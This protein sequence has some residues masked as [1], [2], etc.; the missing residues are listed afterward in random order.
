[1]PSEDCWASEV[2]PMQSM[3]ISRPEPL[4]E[5]VDG[6]IASGHYS[7]ACEYVRELDP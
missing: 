5:F 7:S 6:Q 4:K 1:M 3:N 2:S